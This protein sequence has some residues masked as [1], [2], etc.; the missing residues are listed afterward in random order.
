MME[1]GNNRAS[2]SRLITV[3]SVPDMSPLYLG[4]NQ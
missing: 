2:S 3:N 1:L 4:G